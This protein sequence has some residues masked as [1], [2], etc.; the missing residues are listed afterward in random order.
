MSGEER[1]ITAREAASLVGVSESRIRHWAQTGFIGPSGR[2]DGRPGYTLTDLV[3]LRAGSDLLRQG[4]SLRQARQALDA[5]RTQLPHVS[6]PLAA[7]RVVSDGKQVLVRERDAPYE[8]TTGQLVMDFLVEPLL[9]ADPGEVVELPASGEAAHASLLAGLA[10][11]QAGDEPG[12]ERSY[13]RALELDPRLG[14]AHTN[15]GNLHHRRGEI[16][17][18]RL[19]YERALAVDPEQPEARFNLAN[20]HRDEGQLDRALAEWYRVLSDC[21]EFADA[22][23]NVAATLLSQGAHSAARPHIARFLAL[24]PDGPEADELRRV[25]AQL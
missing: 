5:L 14:A 19:C 18:A 4:I 24:Q 17:R 16:D 9:P 8:V 25:A 1:L 12:A 3:A 6:Q 2:R 11:E 10:L 13:L 22:H 20:L 7:L 23:Y 15:L 21:P